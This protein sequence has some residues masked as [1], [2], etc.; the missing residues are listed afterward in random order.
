M[1]DFYNSSY[2]SVLALIDTAR[3]ACDYPKKALVLGDTWEL[4]E[5]SKD[6]HL[7]IGSLVNKSIFSHLFLF[8]EHVKYIRNGR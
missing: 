5:Y 1:T 2:E 6:I 4:G 8:G 7:A 3:N